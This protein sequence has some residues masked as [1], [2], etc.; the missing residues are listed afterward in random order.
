MIPMPPAMLAGKYRGPM[1]FCATSL[2]QPIFQLGRAERKIVA[3]EALA[4]GPEGG[5]LES[6]VTMFTAA[7][8]L[9]M[10]ARL[11]RECIT[12][13]LSA[14]RCLP[15]GVDV[16]LNVHPATLNDDCEFAAALAEAA[17]QAGVALSR[18]TIE[19]LEYARSAEAGR[20]Q[21]HAALEVLR[22]RGV[23]V[24]VD[25]V[26]GEHDKIRR[27]F[28]YRPDCIKIDGTLVRAGRSDRRSRALVNALLGHARASGA[29]IVAEGIEDPDDLLFVSD[30]GI[31]YAQGF[32][33]CSPL[34]AGELCEAAGWPVPLPAVTP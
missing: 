30:L 6:P 31:E 19:V 5:A 33:L 27:A 11:D 7:R 9:G 18:I 22:D 21:A 23:R 13:G 3:T 10:V 25:D 34:P 8:R 2:L 24:A 14:A 4:R 29:Q 15:A 28:A 26:G 20:P 32:L 16:F 12:A 17:A 1:P